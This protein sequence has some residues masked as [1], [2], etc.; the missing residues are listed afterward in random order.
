M[1]IFVEGSKRA[2][3]TRMFPIWQKMGHIVVDSLEKADVRL[4]VITVRTSQNLPTVLRLDGILY[5]KG[6][7][8]ENVNTRISASYSAVDA[9]VYQSQLAKAMC[10]KYLSKRKTNV[11]DVIYNGI[12]PAGWNNPIAHENIN[13]M[14][15]AKWRRH[16]RLP[17]TVEIFKEFLKHYPTA[18]LHVIGPMTRGS[19]EILYENVIYYGKLNFDRIIEIYRTGDMHLHLSK[20][21]ACPSS[22][23]ES[24]AAGIPVITTNAC[25]GSTEMCQLTEGCAIVPGESESLGADYIYKDPYNKMPDDTKA[26]ILETMKDIA[27]NRRRVDLPQ[28]LSVKHA[29]KKYIDI[30]RSICDG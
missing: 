13:I 19:K 10:E 4:S 15:C 23:V 1:N 11:Y 17:E 6:M 25:G 8:Y 14:C 27:E 5:D 12:D 22:V 18:K 30:M 7:D 24:I 9:V 21:D 16:K 3:V 29:A 2:A 28:E 26:G 20:K